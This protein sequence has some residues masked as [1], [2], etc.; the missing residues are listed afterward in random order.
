MPGKIS[1]ENAQAVRKMDSAFRADAVER[2]HD[3]WIGD[4]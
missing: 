3:A 4:A 2:V 1:R